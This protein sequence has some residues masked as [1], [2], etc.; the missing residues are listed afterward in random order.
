[1][2]RTSNSSTADLHEERQSALSIASAY[3]SEGATANS[4]QAATRKSVKYDLLVQTDHLF[5]L[6]TAEMLGILNEYQSFRS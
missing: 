5:Q 6:I 1:M 4:V 3:N 2:C